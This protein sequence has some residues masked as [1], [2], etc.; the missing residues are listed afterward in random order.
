MKK[1][2]IYVLIGLLVPLAAAAQSSMTDDQVIRF[3][4]KEHE[5]G[6]DEK[7]IVT[8]LMQRGVD[9]QQIRRVKKIAERQKKNAGL[10]MV[11]D[12][13]MTKA[14]D[15]TRKNNTEKKAA[16]MTTQRVQGEQVWKYNY[17]EDDDDFLQMQAEM[18]GLMPVDSIA[19]LEK[20]LAEREKEKKKVFGRDIFSQKDLTFEPSMNVATPQNYVLGPGDAVYI[21]IYGASAKQIETSV[22]PDGYAILTTSGVTARTR[23]VDAKPITQEIFLSLMP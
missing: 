21:D 11:Q 7:Q 17:E 5:A 10:G 23:A 22:S 16:E 19:L 13:T 6:T 18:D 14:N 2:I 20:I 4:L 15:R 12:E 9:I 3:V 1:T 8:K